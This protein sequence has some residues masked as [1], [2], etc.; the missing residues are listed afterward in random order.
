MWLTNKTFHT[1]GY[2][3]HKQYLQYPATFCN[4]LKPYD[5]GNYVARYHFLQFPNAKFAKK[6]KFMY[7]LPL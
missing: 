3:D 4:V 7:I 5:K 2:K 6:Y 1:V